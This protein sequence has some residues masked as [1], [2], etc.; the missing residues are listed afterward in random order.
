MKPLVIIP[1]TVVDK[2]QQLHKT[3]PLNTEWSGVLI[4]T[5]NS[6]LSIKNSVKNNSVNIP[7]EIYV[8]DIVPMNIGSSAS[9]SYTHLTLPTK[10][11]V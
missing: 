9:V 2:I 8:E 4:F 6:N 5:D 11:I 1:Q 10:R 3:A 7:T